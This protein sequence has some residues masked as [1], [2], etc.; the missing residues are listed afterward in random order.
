MLEIIWAVQSST[1]IALDYCTEVL[2][3]NVPK[4]DFK[5]EI[6]LKELLHDIRMDNKAASNVSISEETYQKVLEK[7]KKGKKKT[8]DF[9]VKAGD[10]FKHSVYKWSERNIFHPVLTKQTWFSFTRARAPEMCCQTVG[11]FILKIGSQ[12][13]ASP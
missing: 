10:D 9:L 4:D 1:Y 12:E 2:S 7:I 8:Y 13:H 6:Q 11:L 3:N 5:E